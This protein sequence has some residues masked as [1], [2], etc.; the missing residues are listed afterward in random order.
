MDK[1]H[2]NI[3]VD[4]EL[5]ESFRIAALDLKKAKKITTSDLFRAFVIKF[6]E[7]PNEVVTF[8]KMK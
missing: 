4:D 7:S 1:I 6:V 5:K 3:Q 8:L 2:T